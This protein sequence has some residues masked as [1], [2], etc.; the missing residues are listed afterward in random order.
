V[1]GIDTNRGAK[2]ARES[3]AA[4]GL[5]PAAPLACVLEVAERVGSVVVAALP[6]GVAGACYRDGEAAVL[7]VNGEQAARRQRFTLAH[8]LG[9]AWCRHEGRLE[10]D[11]FETLSGRTSDPFEVQANA[12]AA[13][14]LVPRAGMQARVEGEPTLDDVVRIAA[15]YGVSA[16]VV[17][18]RLKLLK[19]ASDAQIVRLAREV[20]E[21]MHHAL[22]DF[23]GL[24]PLDDRLARIGRL[25]YLSP[26][27]D[28]TLLG[29][30]LR[31]E[32]AVGRE[33][34]SAIATL[35]RPGRL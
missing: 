8:E 9:H 29:A 17:V 25:P 30:A 24:T 22:F 4:L 13:E 35:M 5:D 2:R 27:L 11:T 26:A 12:F 23:L 18:Y 20:E 28:R 16:I 34:S 15:D 7:W 33:L 31:G 32:A 6:D 19:L 21:G 1:A 14:F 3:R 10:P